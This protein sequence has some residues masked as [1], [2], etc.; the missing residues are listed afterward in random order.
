MF[1]LTA[2]RGVEVARQYM[3]KLD[4]VS[5]KQVYAMLNVVA[6]Q[7]YEKTKQKVIKG[8]YSNNG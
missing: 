3:E 5:K 4:D 2:D 8:E 1:N 6:A 7:G